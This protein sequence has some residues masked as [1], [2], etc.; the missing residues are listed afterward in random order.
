LRD[1]IGHGT[2]KQLDR[3]IPSLRT[4]PNTT[5]DERVAFGAL[6][7]LAARSGDLGPDAKRY[8]DQLAELVRSLD[9]TLLEE[10]VIGADLRRQAAGL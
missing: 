9:Q 10:P 8:S 3:R 2:G 1:R 6:R 5:I 7:D 4:R